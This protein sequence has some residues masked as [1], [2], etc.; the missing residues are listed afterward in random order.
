MKIIF[1]ICALFVFHHLGAQAYKD[2]IKN[3][4]G[5]YTDLLLKKDFAKSMDYLNPAIYKIAP[6]EQLQAIMEQVF[7]NPD[8]EIKLGKAEMKPVADSQRINNMNYATFEYTN[9]MSMRFISEEMKQD[10]GATRKALAGQFGDDNV[11]F[12]AGTEEYHIKATK[13]VIANSADSRKWTFLVVE[14]RQRA[15]LETIVPKELL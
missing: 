9:S 11:R 5:Y 2:S 1:L 15:M 3:Q 14:E 10:T 12:D 4:F 13:K 8:I 6:K 7:N